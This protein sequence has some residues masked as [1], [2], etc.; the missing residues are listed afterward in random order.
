MK[1]FFSEP[2]W[3]KELL[4]LPD[5]FNGFSKETLEALSTRLK[6]VQS[7]NPLVSIVIAAW[8]EEN[9]IIR[10]LTS[11]ANNKT[12][13]PFDI[14]VVD[15]NSTDNTYSIVK[16]LGVRCY[17]ERTQ[18]C[19]PAREL[20][21]RKA[22]GKY[23][24]LADADCLY[25]TSWISVMTNKLLEDNV[26]CVYGNFNFYAD[27]NTKRWHYSI[28]EMFRNLKR[29]LRHI[30]RPYLNAYGLN[31]GYIKSYGIEIGYINHNTRGDDG[32]LCYALMNYGRV[33][34]VSSN[35]A[36]VWTTARTLSKQGTILEAFGQNFLR[37]LVNINSYFTTNSPLATD[38]LDANFVTTEFI[39]T[40]EYF[41][42]LKIKTL[43][44]FRKKAKKK[45]PPL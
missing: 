16:N 36:L 41:V 20:G 34:M 23:I 27:K 2:E 11:I 26:V 45:P 28:Y 24:L 32:R 17:F 7:P 21:Q 12:S 4:S 1:Y 44:L 15:N 8:N 10:C 9:H 18:G 42:I 33:H 5:K 35:H 22:K 6:A 43:S 38:S 30:K 25:P 40:K 3:V 29:M 14:V 13:I 37:E 31:M 19:G 39:T